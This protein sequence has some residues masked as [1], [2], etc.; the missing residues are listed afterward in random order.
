MFWN[1]NVFELHELC[2]GVLLNC[3]VVWYGYLCC[4]CECTKMFDNCN[5]IWSYFCIVLFL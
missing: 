4:F 2:Y 5:L 3:I 1:K